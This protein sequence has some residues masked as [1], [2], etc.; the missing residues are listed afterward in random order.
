MESVWNTERTDKEWDKSLGPGVG[1]GLQPRPWSLECV[2]RGLRGGWRASFASDE[3][4]VLTGTGPFFIFKSKQAVCGGLGVMGKEETVM[5]IRLLH[6]SPSDNKTKQEGKHGKT[7]DNCGG[8]V[9]LLTLSLIG[10][11]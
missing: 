11:A 10:K 6:T 7:T 5:L 3:G 1:A 8:M 2:C 9:A 4:H